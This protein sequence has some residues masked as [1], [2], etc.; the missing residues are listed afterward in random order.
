MK[1]HYGRFKFKCSIRI[2]NT[3]WLK[4][5]NQQLRVVSFDYF[6]NLFEWSHLGRSVCTVCVA[7]FC[8]IIFLMQFSSVP[9]VCIVVSSIYIEIDELISFKKH[10]KWQKSFVI[11]ALHA[12]INSKLYAHMIR[13]YWIREKQASQEC[14]QNICVWF[15]FRSISFSHSRVF[16]Y[17][18]LDTEPN[19]IHIS[20]CKDIQFLFE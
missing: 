4:W 3:G 5:Q 6:R 16:W 12:K 8:Y 10:L 1:K 18:M 17:I 19:Q 2:A 11:Y 9:S 7:Y 14:S 13:Y 15:F 20:H